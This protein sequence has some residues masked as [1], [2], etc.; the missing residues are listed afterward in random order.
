MS[1]NAIAYYRVSTELQANTG[2]SLEGQRATVRRYVLEED[3]TLISEHTEAESAYRYSSKLTIE[4]RPGLRDALRDCKRHKATLVI[5]AL[6]RLARNVVFIAS[7]IETRVKFVALDIPNATP[8]MIHIYAAV[9]EEESRQKG[10]LVSAALMLA[11]ARGKYWGQGARRMSEAAQARAEAHRPIFDEIRAMGIR[12]PHRIAKELRRQNVPCP[13]R[14]TWTAQMVQPMLRRLGYYERSAV[15]WTKQ[16]R[17]EALARAEAL[18]PIVD[19][20]RAAGCTDQQTA[21]F[22]NARGYRTG[23]GRPWT[24][25][26]VYDLRKRYPRNGV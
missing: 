15:P 10:R 3:L 17:I 5:A 13:T 20:L 2:F 12:G 6:D 9:A 19:E 26:G 14:E 1:G 4:K 11:K 21:E 18:R 7:L 16:I 8:F 25:H 24:H 23:W 22:L